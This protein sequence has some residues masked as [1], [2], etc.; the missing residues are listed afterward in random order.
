MVGANVWIHWVKS[1]ATTVEQ[2][3][4]ALSYIVLQKNITCFICTYL[5]LKDII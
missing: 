2:L 3:Q 4:V 5:G 1:T